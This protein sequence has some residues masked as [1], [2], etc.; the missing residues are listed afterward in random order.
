MARQILVV[1][2]DVTDLTDEERGNL[3][4]EVVTQAERS[5]GDQG[6]PSVEVV[7]VEIVEREEDGE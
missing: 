4:L 5:K 6:H 1:E 7:D 2:F 3:T